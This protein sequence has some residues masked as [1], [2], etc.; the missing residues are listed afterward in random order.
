MSRARSLSV[1]RALLG[2]GLLL[3][4][5]AHAGSSDDAGVRSVFAVGAGNRALALGSAFVGV[6]DDASAPLWN[7]GGLGLVTRAELQFSQASLA[8]P[9]IRE[10]FL[11]VVMPGWRWGVAS[12]TLRQLGADDIEGRDSRNVMFADNLSDRET[13]TTIAYARPMGEAWAVG[14]MAKLRRQEVAGRSASGL[15][16]DLGV[17]VRPGLALG[18]DATWAHELTLGL[19]LSN[20][21]EPGIRLDQETVADPAGA[22]V[23]LAWQH[24]LFVVGHVLGAL[25][26]ERSR[27]MAPRLHLGFEV[28]PWPMFA[29]R[30]GLNAGGL[31]AG[32]GIRWASTTLDYAFEDGPIGATHRAGLTF[33]FGRSTTQ[34]RDAEALADEERLQARLASVDHARQAERSAGLLARASEARARGQCDSAL[35]A[36]STLEAL[37]PGNAEAAAMSAACLRDQGASLEASGD[38]A[39]AA[40]AYGRALSALPGDSLAA[41][42]QRRCRAENDRRLTGSEAF[43]RQFAAA[44]DAFSREDLGAARRDFARLLATS[45]ADSE[46]RAMLGRVDRAIARRADNLIQQAQRLLQA[47]LLDDAAVLLEQARGLDTDARGLAAA[48]AALAYERL[49]AE[50]ARPRAGTAP[51]GGTPR[52]TVPPL[53]PR[54]ARELADLYKRGMAAMEH[55]RSDDALRYWEIVW[56][57]R[58]GYERVDQ[59]LKREY[60]TRGMEAFAAGRLGEAVR[61]WE[62]ALRVDPA[63]Q[64]TLG[65]LARAH[66]QLDRAREISGQ[67]P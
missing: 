8:A 57:A 62:A 6:A 63:D 53:S 18:R 58:P 66:E 10:S 48:D 26:V 16:A 14:G 38:F 24:P 30:T 4:A 12:F 1:L 25:D 3:A 52:P 21:V 54:Q 27:G 34:A 49:S 50:H 31:T 41:V 2:F 28:S 35:V 11:G 37:D 17:M 15:G 65:Y 23:G 40:I 7:P 47:G 36:L 44:L 51:A 20:L 61:L 22:R 56:A 33:Q 43:R 9:G 42:A 46:A 39:A 19:A 5:P 55:G 13:E 64:R 60:Q 59:Y 67:E 29:L 45:P 32:T